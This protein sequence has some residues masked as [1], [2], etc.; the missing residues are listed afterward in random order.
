MQGAL[1]NRETTGAPIGGLALAKVY[2]QNGNTH[3]GQSIIFKEFRR[4]GW[5]ENGN[6]TIKSPQGIA[7]L[8]RQ[9]DDD[10]YWGRRTSDATFAKLQRMFDQSHTQ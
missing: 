1:F 7:L 10:A 3:L 9:I 6:W 8:Y 5:I 4:R 2:V